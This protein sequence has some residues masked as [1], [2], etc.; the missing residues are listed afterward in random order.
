MREPRRCML[1]ESVSAT[2]VEWMQSG[3]SC[4]FSLIDRRLLSLV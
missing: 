1:N 4:G 2:G 3:I